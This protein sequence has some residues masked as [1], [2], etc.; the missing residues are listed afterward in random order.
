MRRR[1]P[2]WACPW[3]RPSPAQ[4]CCEFTTCARRE[5][6]W[7]PAG[8]CWATCGRGRPERARSIGGTGGRAGKDRDLASHDLVARNLQHK[9]VIA[10]RD[11]VADVVIKEGAEHV[12]GKNQAVGV[13][14]P[15]L[16]IVQV[17]LDPHVLVRR[18]QAALR[19]QRLTLV[20]RRTAIEETSADKDRADIEVE[21]FVFVRDSPGRCQKVRDFLQAEFLEFV[22]TIWTAESI[23][24]EFVLKRDASHARAQQSRHK[25][26]AAPGGLDGRQRLSDGCRETADS[27]SKSR[28]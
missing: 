24:I 26:A 25:G 14:D 22:G 6:F 5:T 19:P 16:R 13:D 17:A 1:R 9:R 11:A 2:R 10:G 15:I 3:Q 21:H 12:A 27:G 28:D 20:K 18:N 23:A 8:L 4:T 7:A